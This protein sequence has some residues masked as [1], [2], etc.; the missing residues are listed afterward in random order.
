MYN[1][2]E[3]PLRINNIHYT[4][5]L[6]RPVQKHFPVRVNTAIPNQAYLPLYLIV[7]QPLPTMTVNALQDDDKIPSVM[8]GC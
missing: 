4:V 7:S 2:T 1:N 6:P 5:L 8:Q 3:L